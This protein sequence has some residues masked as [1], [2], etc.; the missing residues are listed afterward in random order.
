MSGG[1]GSTTTV[2]KSDPWSGQQPYLQNVFSGAQNAYNQY[3]GNPASSVA[4]FTP[5]Q[6]QAMGLTQNVANGTNF[7]NAS[8]VNNAAGN[9]TTNLLN[10]NYLNANPGNAAFSQFANGSMLNNPYQSAA[11]DAA[12]N[13]ITRAY[14]TAT[15]PQT[16]SS[17]AG[18]GRYG[19]GAYQN[20]VS[21]N[22]QDLATQLG[23]TD[24]SLVNS[25][26]QQN[27]AN[28]LQGA[29]GLSSN[30][31]T[32]A[33]QQ[34]AGSANAPNVVNSINGAATNL[35]NMGGNQQA[36]SQAQ[37][38]APWQLLNNYSNLI[39]GQYGS[40][41][42]A[43]QPYYSNQMAG[44]L[45]GAMSGATMGSMFGPWGAGIGAIG[46]GLLGAFSD[47][48]LKTDIEPTGEHLENGLPLYRYRYL[49]DIPHVRRVGVMADEVRRVAPHAVW[50]DASGFDKVD[51]AAI[52]GSHV[53]S[54]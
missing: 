37:I 53:L 24:A 22:Q 30:Y 9:Y 25:M 6:Q 4:G 27:M 19:S 18:S 15:A 31:N 36:L 5:M 20:A 8:G 12:N 29:Q 32:A 33:Q 11:L 10:G 41:T 7:G 26:Y 23:N 13:A 40:S 35:Y 51:Y 43:T 14:Q 44:G 17:F 47:R 16:A 2:Q 50:R 45:G 3:S 28:M 46:G 1:G 38:N 54:W 52:G 34:L 49:W 48:R 39:Q 42:T 21:Q